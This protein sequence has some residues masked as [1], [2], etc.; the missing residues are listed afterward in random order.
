MQHFLPN[1]QVLLIRPPLLEDAPAL[2]ALF[3][4]LTTET[5]FLLMTRHEAA[6]LTVAD[7]KAFISS[8][9]NASK[10]LHLLAIVENRLTGT[11]SVKQS[12][13]KK[14]IH[15]GQLGI[16]V[17]HEYWN[18]GIA[19]RLMTTAMRWAEQH[20]ELEIIQLSVFANNER[21]VQLYRNFD[22]HE[23][24]RLQQGFKQI[25]GTYGDAILMSKRIKNR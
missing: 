17:L 10:H 8:L 5:D 2:L 24:G 23:Y 14:E 7:E 20:R 3:Q 12:D 6:T 11:L 4:Q 22:F 19:R 13:L 16:A 15:L 25:D 21:A 9:S 18:M 1:G